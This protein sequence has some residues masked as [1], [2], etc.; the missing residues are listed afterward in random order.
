MRRVL[1]LLSGDPTAALGPAPVGDDLLHEIDIGEAP[2]AQLPQDPEPV[3]V[4]PNVATAIDGV[5]ES[6]QTRERAPHAVSFPAAG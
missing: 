6:V 4:D 2:L 3:L 5:V 1:D